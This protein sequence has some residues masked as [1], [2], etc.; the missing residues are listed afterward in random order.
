MSIP[1]TIHRQ[2]S[3]VPKYPDFPDTDYLLLDIDL[4][5]DV[6]TH[7]MQFYLV[8][9]VGDIDKERFYRDFVAEIAESRG[10]L[11]AIADRFRIDR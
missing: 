7:H 3:N 5:L 1:I 11:K 9:M 8:D 10:R 2:T 6:L 4:R